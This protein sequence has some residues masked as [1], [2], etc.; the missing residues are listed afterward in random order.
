M[1][2]SPLLLLFLLAISTQILAQEFDEIYNEKN[3][4]R[5]VLKNNKYGYID[6]SDKII[7]SP[8]YDDAFNFQTNGVA[9]VYQS[10][11]QGLINT[12]GEVIL[13]IIYDKIYTFKYGYA[14]VKKDNFLFSLANL[15][16]KV[17][18]A[19]AASVFVFP[20]ALQVPQVQTISLSLG[21]IMYLL[22]A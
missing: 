22:R 10:N 9:L 5:I 6:G 13:P 7:V 18:T 21:K 15:F 4:F 11:K 16:K 12:K 1:K 8:K 20:A 2:K 3:G 17:K 14:V 19:G